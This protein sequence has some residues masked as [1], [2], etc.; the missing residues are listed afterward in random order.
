MTIFFFLLHWQHYNAVQHWTTVTCNAHS[1]T[2]QCNVAAQEGS[3]TAPTSMHPVTLLL[4]AKASILVTLLN[5]NTTAMTPTHHIS[6]TPPIS[7]LGCANKMHASPTKQSRTIMCPS[8][9]TP[10]TPVPPT[11]HRRR[12]HASPTLRAPHAPRGPH[13]PLPPHHTHHH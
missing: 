1:S 13:T 7:Q 12:R 8:V 9:P 4:T 10:P 6:A 3:H 5:H 2:L 11:P